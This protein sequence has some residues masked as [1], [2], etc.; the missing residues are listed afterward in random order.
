MIREKNKKTPK[1]VINNHI[2]DVFK[3]IFSL[4]LAIF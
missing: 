1:V 3:I 2:K 4:P